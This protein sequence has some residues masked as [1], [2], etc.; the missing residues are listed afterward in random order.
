MKHHSTRS[1]LYCQ[2][3]AGG[4]RGGDACTRDF[5]NTRLVCT[6]QWNSVYDGGGGCCVGC[7]G[8]GDGIGCGNGG[9]GN[10]GSGDGGSVVVVVVMIA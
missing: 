2:Y 4:R 7:G 6:F 3:E 8:S 5:G 1:A 10:G 9:S